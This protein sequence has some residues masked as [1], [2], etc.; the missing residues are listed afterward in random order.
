MNR[1]LALTNLLIV[2]LSGLML[3]FQ[4][5]W[6][7]HAIFDS[8]YLIHAHSHLAL[9]GWLLPMIF[10]RFSPE[11]FAKPW[12]LAYHALVW[13]MSVAFLIQG[14]AFWSIT[15]STVVM[16]ASS[17]AAVRLFD[18]GGIVAKT[19]LALM[20]VSNVGP[21]ALG[22]GAFMGPEWIRGWVTF[23]L[24][25]QFT[26]WITLA[27]LHTKPIAHPERPL[28]M[29]VIGAVLLLEPYFRTA[30]TPLWMQAIGVTGG[31]LTVGGTFVWM[32]H[33][34]GF[35]GADVAMTLKSL[36]QFVA[37]LPGIGTALL[38][39]HSV[40][41]AF[42]HLVL[43]AMATHRLL[44]MRRTALFLIGIWSMIAAL[45]L[46]GTGGSLGIPPLPHPQ[47][48]FLLTG[49][50]TLVGVVVRLWPRTL[51]NTSIQNQTENAS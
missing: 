41:I 43:V 1:P 40:G 27:V 25:L 17:V 47:F 23:Y 30:S 4:W 45:M 2:L 12:V 48:V 5:T 29:M 18:T 31:V 42:A 21:L 19:A 46:F 44:P 3:R 7:V 24:H 10:E 6:P 8:R 22:A 35:D 34:R 9:L 36:A 50:A 37:S 51:S 28:A 11:A 49:V 38:V 33:V 26:G 13:A 16:M 14:Y 39:N 15:L 32:S 20:W